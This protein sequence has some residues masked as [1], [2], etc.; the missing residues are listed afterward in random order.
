M[1]KNRSIQ[2][3]WTVL[4]NDQPKRNQISV[5]LHFSLTQMLVVAT[6]VLLVEMPGDDHLALLSTE[7]FGELHEV[8]ILTVAVRREEVQSNEDRVDRVAN[9]AH[10]RLQHSRKEGLEVERRR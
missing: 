4:Q 1:Y 9:A 5:V 2:N 6:G 10:E 8:L 7:L 3:A